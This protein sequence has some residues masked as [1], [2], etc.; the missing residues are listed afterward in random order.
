MYPFIL[1]AQDSDQIEQK[2]VQAIRADEPIKVDGVLDEKVW[3]GT[4]YSDFVQYDPI[5]GAEPTEKTIV[6]VAYDDSSLYVAARL[7]DSEP[8]KI[9]SR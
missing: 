7:L 8:G 3:Q 2:V 9:V 4:G 6:W 1:L 5:N